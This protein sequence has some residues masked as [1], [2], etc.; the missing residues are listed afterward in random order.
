MTTGMLVAIA[1]TALAPYTMT[2]VLASPCNLSLTTVS[3]DVVRPPSITPLSDWS[4]S[5]TSSTPLKEVNGV[6]Q[7]TLEGKFSAPSLSI[8]SGNLVD[9]VWSYNKAGKLLIMLSGSGFKADI[10]LLNLPSP[11]FTFSGTLYVDGG[12]PAM[13]VKQSGSIT[14][15]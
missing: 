15:A 3:G 9:G 1:F 13:L 2:G 11:G 10:A 5:I 7:G 8:G 4:F 12:R 14:C 6:T